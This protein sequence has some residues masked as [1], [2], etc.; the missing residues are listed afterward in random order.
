M[1]ERKTIAKL[2]DNPSKQDERDFLREV[3][4]GVPECSY[5]A[6]LFSADMI[7]WVEAQI[8]QDVSC[9]LWGSF[10][11]AVKD[12][13]VRVNQEREQVR[14]AQAE[15]GDCKRRYDALEKV[16][17]AVRGKH[18]MAEEKAQLLHDR[19]QESQAEA[20]AAQ[21]RFYH[22]TTEIDR[23][24]GEIMALKAKLYDAMTA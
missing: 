3:A 21:D 23:L 18:E 11:Y 5:L 15:T 1:G 14:A 13:A 4:A 12:A 17:E 7:Q 16:L 10:D 6:S 20:C 9:D 19:W 22:A 2:A 8:R 24:Q